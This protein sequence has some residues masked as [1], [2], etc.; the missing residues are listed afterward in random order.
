MKN[1]ITGKIIEEAERHFI[2]GN[3]DE[4]E[5]SCNVL[6]EREP[7]NIESLFLLGNISAQKGAIRDALKHFSRA[8]SI[9]PNLPVLR[10]NLGISLKLMQKYEESIAEFKEAVRLDPE[11]AP[12]WYQLGE[13]FEESNNLDEALQ[14]YVKTIELEP[15]NTEAIQR[16]GDIYQKQNRLHEALEYYRKA[17]RLKPGNYIAYN[18]AGGILKSLSRTREALAFFRN[19]L[20]IKPDLVLCG[21]NY[22]LTMLLSSENSPVDISNAH[23]EW[24]DAY[25]TPLIAHHTSHV[26]AAETD[27]ALRI[28]YVSADFKSHPVAFFIEP[29]LAAHNREKLTVF[30]YSNCESPDSITAQ[31][32]RLADVWR[33][34]HNV[35]DNEV[36]DIIRN[37]GIDILVD[38]GGHTLRN[39]L[40]VFARK[41][42]PVQVTWLGY[43]ATTGLKSIDYRITDAEADPPGLTEHLHSE[44]LY[45]LPDTF[46]CYRPPVN[47]PAVAPLPSLTNGHITFGVFNSFSKIT[48]D[49][50]DLWCKILHLI[51]EAKLLIKAQGMEHEPM[52]AHVLEMFLSRGIPAKKI[53]LAGQTWSIYSHLEMFGKV[54]ISLDTFPYNGTTTT[55][56]SLWMGVPVIAKEGDSHVSRVG[57]SLLGAVGLTGLIAASA[58]DYVSLA[59]FLARDTNNLKILRNNLRNRMQASKL[60]DTA[61]FTRNLEAAYRDMWQ[62]WCMEQAREK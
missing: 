30:C 61:G 20:K 22:L 38:L 58:E 24:S 53:E 25:E 43:P 32:E 60:L 48:R 59:T 1:E 54:D 50:V 10:L 4:A 12:A 35:G 51:P 39:R 16:T 8:V 45:R 57:V 62:T 11:Y 29:I 3:L 9:S 40:T 28:G 37:D 21:C 15:L 5:L 33:P 2:S 19:A 52:R 7:D 18:N 34:I 42:A 27:K 23:K 6:L 13:V 36:C 17:I 31:L 41:P 26:N 55:C 46:I 56:E 47:A 14:A 49:A 44:T